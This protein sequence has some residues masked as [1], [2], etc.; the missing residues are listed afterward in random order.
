MVASSHHQVSKPSGVGQIRSTQLTYWYEALPLSVSGP[1]KLSQINKKKAVVKG[2]LVASNEREARLQLRQQQLAPIKLGVFTSQQ[3]IGYGK[4]SL[5]WWETIFHTLY[6]KQ[7]QKELIHQLHQYCNQSGLTLL[8]ALPL[9]ENNTPT[10]RWRQHFYQW[11]QQLINGYPWDVWFQQQQSLWGK[12]VTKLL[13]TG[14]QQGQLLQTIGA[15]HHQLDANQREH[16][17]LTYPFVLTVGLV[18]F[19]AVET[20]LAFSNHT[21]QWSWQWLSIGLGSTWILCLTAPW[22]RSLVQRLFATIPG[23]KSIWQWWQAYQWLR[24]WQLS[25]TIAGGGSN[26]PSKG[27]S[28]NTLESLTLTTKLIDNPL[29]KAMLNNCLKRIDDGEPFQQALDHL[30]YIPKPMAD[31]FAHCSGMDQL[32]IL[33]EQFFDKSLKIVVQLKAYGLAVLSLLS[34]GWILY[35]H[36]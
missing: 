12:T 35:L 1:S 7:H 34:I 15:I 5:P 23:V 8:D 36:G 13:L 31:G 33:V 28:I 27:S 21:W 29:I 24:L 26:M 17:W 30:P 16:R 6:L 20:G 10:Q 14:Q 11:R 18:V 3:N 19:A 4:D 32:P 25:H 9:M 2:T 22:V